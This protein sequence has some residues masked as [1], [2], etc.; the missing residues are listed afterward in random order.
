[1]IILRSLKLRRLSRWVAQAGVLYVPWYIGVFGDISRPVLSAGLP[2]S[3]SF[4][5]RH[6]PSCGARYDLQRSKWV[7][8]PCAVPYNQIEAGQALLHI[9]LAAVTLILSVVVVLE[10]RREKHRL[11][12]PQQVQYA[13][14][15]RNQLPPPLSI[16][17]LG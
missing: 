12:P 16:S 8:S 9:I 6:T 14:I 15:K 4:F 2:Y 1:M 17:E 10:R 5:L 13:Q 3:Y 7:Q 11:K